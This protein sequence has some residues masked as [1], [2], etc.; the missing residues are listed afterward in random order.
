MNYL[1]F[2]AFIL[3]Q[4]NYGNSQDPC[5]PLWPRIEFGNVFSDNTSE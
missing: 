4:L 2:I 3:I 5:L 1:I